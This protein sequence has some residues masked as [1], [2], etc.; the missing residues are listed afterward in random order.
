MLAQGRKLKCEIRSSLG[1]DG[2]AITSIKLLCHDE[3][4]RH[5]CSDTGEFL[6]YPVTEAWCHLLLYFNLHLVSTSAS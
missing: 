3:K 5:V 2:G 1:E 4:K 6:H